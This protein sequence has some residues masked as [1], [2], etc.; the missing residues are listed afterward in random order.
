MNVLEAV[1]SNFSVDVRELTET[2]EYYES[3]YSSEFYK[4]YTKLKGIYSSKRKN[5]NRIRDRYKYKK[6]CN[7]LYKLRKNIS[8]YREELI[9]YNKNN[10]E[11]YETS[12]HYSRCKY[13][14]LDTPFGILF[15]YLYDTLFKEDFNL[16]YVKKNY[17]E[18]K[19]K[20]RTCNLLCC[21]VMYSY[22]AWLIKNREL[23][24]KSV[25]KFVDLYKNELT[26]ITSILDDLYNEKYGYN[27]Y[28]IYNIIFDVKTRMNKSLSEYKGFTAFTSNNNLVYIIGSCDKGV[29]VL[30]LDGIEVG[31][32]SSSCKF[33]VLYFNEDGKEVNDKDSVLFNTLKKVR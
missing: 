27:K 17:E 1:N 33:P 15:K 3:L 29:A 5:L 13:S 30:H 10:L 14:L 21:S 18:I 19:D 7:N 4:K 26:Y 25:G 2:K 16:E 28:S 22:N 31:S 20:V 11:A 12:L 9:K 6:A 32:D 8:K 24:D 23:E